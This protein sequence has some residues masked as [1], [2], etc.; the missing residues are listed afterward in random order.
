M[1]GA[2]YAFRKHFYSLLCFWLALAQDLLQRFSKYHMLY[3]KCFYVEVISP[4]ILGKAAKPIVGKN[5]PKAE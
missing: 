2:C 5:K 4:R 1:L 3:L